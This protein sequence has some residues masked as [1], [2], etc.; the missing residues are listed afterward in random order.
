MKFQ[1]DSNTYKD[2]LTKMKLKE[3]SFELQ[4]EKE[5]LRHA[6]IVRSLEKEA[7]DTKCEYEDKVPT[8]PMN[9]KSYLMSNS[10][11]VRLIHLG[12]YI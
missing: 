1:Q 8:L 9:N 5:R 11:V 2:M 4:L 12:N 3:K 7:I 6:D 10:N